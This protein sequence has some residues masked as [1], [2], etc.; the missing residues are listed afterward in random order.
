MQYAPG[1]RTFLWGYHVR[2]SFFVY[3][4]EK[5]F[6]KNHAN[7]L[8]LNEFYCILRLCNEKEGTDINGIHIQRR[9]AHR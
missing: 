6:C 9:S 2:L 5:Y 8:I 1:Q 4:Y 7:Y 3:K